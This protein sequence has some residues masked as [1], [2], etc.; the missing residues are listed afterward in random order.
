MGKKHSPTSNPCSRVWDRRAK[1]TLL[2]PPLRPILPFSARGTMFYVPIELVI[3]YEW[4][5][6]FLMQP[7]TN[8]RHVVD[9]D[10]HVFGFLLEVLVSPS[11]L[12]GTEPGMNLV[13]LT[14]AMAMS[15]SFGMERE[16]DKLSATLKRY[17]VQRVLHRN[18]H[19]PDPLGAMDHEYFVF[20]SEELYRAHC[21]IS[22]HEGLAEVFNPVEIG[23]LYW[24]AIPRELWPALTA[25]FDEDFSSSIDAIAQVEVGDPASRFSYLYKE[26]FRSAGYMT[27]GWAAQPRPAHGVDGEQM[28]GQG[29]HGDLQGA[30]HAQLTLAPE[31]AMDP[32]SD[33]DI[34]ASGSSLQGTLEDDNGGYDVFGL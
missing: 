18:P 12:Q 32:C 25:D 15:I 16:F 27:P 13:T 22:A 29:R 6:N 1:L 26:A 20:R 33:L 19:L 5:N 4:W 9:I 21:M 17:I 8:P 11:G 2:F 24:L 23:T 7:A 28:Q 10:P 34:M 3:D 14:A 30:S 31:V